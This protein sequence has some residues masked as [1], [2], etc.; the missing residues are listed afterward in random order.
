MQWD[1]ADMKTPLS[2]QTINGQFGLMLFSSSSDTDDSLTDGTH[3]VPVTGA[4]SHTQSTLSLPELPQEP[5]TWKP[6]STVLF[7][8][9]MCHGW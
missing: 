1:E 6:S 5:H 9:V 2:E 7:I 4:S 8:D 3:G